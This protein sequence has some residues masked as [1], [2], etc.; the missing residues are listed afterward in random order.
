MHTT[1][2]GIRPLQVC[3]VYQLHVVLYLIMHL[4]HQV[5]RI[6]P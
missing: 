1:S 2:L 6:L 3:G 5:G 4:Q